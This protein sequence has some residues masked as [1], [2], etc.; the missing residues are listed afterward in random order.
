MDNQT[1]TNCSVSNSTSGSGEKPEAAADDVTRLLW[2]VCGP[3]LLVVGGVGNVLILATMTQRRMKGTSTCV[4]LCAMAVVDL[5][6]LSTGLTFN[7]LEGA[8]YVT[9]KVS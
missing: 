6:V 8:E 2:T 5:M 7:W 3:T 9:V 4:Y 1:V